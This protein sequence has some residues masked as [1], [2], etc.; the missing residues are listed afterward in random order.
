METGS[1]KKGDGATGRTASARSG[2]D[3]RSARS[4]FWR[5]I[6]SHARISSVTSSSSRAEVEVCSRVPCG[7]LRVRELAELVADVGWRD[8]HG[9]VVLAVVDQERRAVSVRALP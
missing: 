9:Q 6:C 3:R 7:F 2:T 1:R 8:M 5:A 4:R